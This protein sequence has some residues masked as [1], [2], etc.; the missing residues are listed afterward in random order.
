MA[1][2]FII[3]GSTA[4]AADATTLRPEVGKPLQGAQDD[5]K[6]GKYKDALA[7][8]RDAEAVSGKTS[9]ES[10]MIE[11]MRA[12][13]AQGAGDSALA[14]KS[15]EAV[16]NSGH[17]TGAAQTKIVQ[18][19]GEMY[20]QAKEYPKAIIWLT[21][22]IN[23]GGDDARMRP[24]LIN[25]YYLNGEYARAGKETLAQIQADEKAGRS[26]SD[27]QLQMLASCAIKQNDKAGYVQALEK[28]VTYHPKKE[29]WVDLLN[30]LEN[31]TG[32][33][34]SRLGLDVYRLRMAV[35]AVTSANDFMNMAELALQAGY[36]SEAKKIIETA[37]KSGA[38]GSGGE[39]PRQK[40]LQDLAAKNAADDLKTLAKTEADVS[41]SKDG[42]GM[43]NVGYDYVTT[44]QIDKGIA[45][46][47]Q[48][49]E[50][51][52]LKRPDD[53][54]LH[55]ALAYLQADKKTKA[56][57]TFKTVQGTDGTAE[58]AHYWML[59]INHPLN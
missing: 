15:Y 49:I 18:V 3:G 11:Y 23:D 4:Y 28:M 57:Q 52:N 24:L 16:I 37:F 10:Y 22:Y 21:R 5:I 55:L 9:Y 51:G 14:A 31:K 33:N 56:L 30:R 43:V 40:R 7:K 44:G 6:K 25:A 42:T 53:A 2:G 45:L 59:E 12:A 1:P 26:P 8:I 13:A 54:K 46:M 36:P 17:V 29:L 41:T 20:Y 50:K 48:G 35:G 32:F 39:A 27:E 19:L 34:D 58:I 38:F 47:E